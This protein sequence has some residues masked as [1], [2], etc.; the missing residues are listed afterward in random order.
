MPMTRR[1]FLKRAGVATAGTV[2]GPKLFGNPFVRQAFA[3]TIGD[4]Y[5]VVLYFD[6]GNDADPIKSLRYE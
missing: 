2:L 3:E 4:R 5:L 1:Q 6:G